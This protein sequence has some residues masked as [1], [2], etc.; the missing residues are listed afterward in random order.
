M[1]TQDFIKTWRDKGRLVDL[2]GHEI[3]VVDSAGQDDASSAKPVLMLVHGFPTASVDW[4]PMWD[5]LATHFRLLALD[6]LGFGFSDKPDG[7]QHYSIH[8]QADLF[9]ALA[10]KYKVDTYHLFVHDYGVSVAQEMLSRDADRETQTI[11]SCCFLNGGLFPETH[12]AL[13][14][15]KILLGPFGKLLNLLSNFKT[16][17][18]SFS[19]VFGEHTKPSEEELAAFWGVINYNQGKHILHNGITYMDDRKKHRSRWLHTLQNATLPLSLINGSVDPVSGAHLV[20][21]YKELNCRLDHV[22]QLE[23]IGHYP[24]VEAP[25]AVS[26][27]Y[28]A[29]Y[30][31]KVIG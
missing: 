29:F 30:Q 4:A 20:D 2:A 9:E 25:E 12:Q 26:D 28:L 16:F 5:K 14:I 17:K 27:A 11:K 24:H 18:K 7:R 8:G 1:L 21:R 15:Q 22:E 3:F 19:H 23:T 31:T 10:A 6:M 13:L